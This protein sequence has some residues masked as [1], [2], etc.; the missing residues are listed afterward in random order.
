MSIDILETKAGF[1]CNLNGKEL[2]Y[3]IGESLVELVNFDF[4]ELNNL[5]NNFV[6]TDNLTYEKFF[7]NFFK[8]YK[9]KND[10]FSIHFELLR[11]T[12][13]TFYDRYDDGDID[14]SVKPFPYSVIPD[15][16]QENQ[17]IY[18]F[19]SS[20]FTMQYKIR[21]I[22]SCIVECEDENKIKAL[23]ELSINKKNKANMVTLGD[24][25]LF[26]FT[27]RLT[28]SIYNEYDELFYKPPLFTENEICFP[29]HF[30]EVETFCFY[31]LRRLLNSSI[32]IIRCPICNKFVASKD[33]RRIYC[34]NKCKG[35]AFEQNSNQTVYYELYRKRY[36]YLHNYYSEHNDIDG[37]IPQNVK[38]ELKKLYTKYAD[39]SE[40]DKNLIKEYEIKLKKIK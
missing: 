8:L 4:S 17:R 20:L 21:K 14:P 28:N 27:P 12:L 22:L 36:R 18:A 7:S 35:K 33:E 3:K 1:I 19:F 10:K 6:E 23:Y 38:N 16:K 31:E 29:L 30:T 11:N 25:D 13:C 9:I 34:S 15:P 5:L 2:N 37:T 32:K 26:D 40:N 39:R 24:V